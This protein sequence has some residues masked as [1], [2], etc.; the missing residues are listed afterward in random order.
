M[1]AVTRPRSITVLALL[2]IAIGTVGFVYHFPHFYGERTYQQEDIW[3]ELT[4]A[5]AI[6]SGAFLLR[7]KNWARW[8]ALAWM[9]FH[10]MLS[11]HEYPKLAIHC[12]FGA[13]IA[14]CLFSPSAARYFRRARSEPM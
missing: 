8:L 5:T 12:L 2:Y 13:V 6:I 9:A 1:N 4:E 3:I 14:V 7:G 10:I 11:I